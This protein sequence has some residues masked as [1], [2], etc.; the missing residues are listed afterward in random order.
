MNT[1]IDANID[2][3]YWYISALIPGIKNCW[4]LRWWLVQAFSDSGLGVM[5]LHV[6]A[7]FGKNLGGELES[8][9][10]LSGQS[11]SRF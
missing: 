4:G 2:N 3:A 6:A 11:C 10:E 5:L 1:N 9:G 7:V 8:R